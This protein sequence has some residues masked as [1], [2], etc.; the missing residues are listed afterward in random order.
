MN[1]TEEVV[2][3]S[4]VEGMR[5]SASTHKRY[6]FRSREEVESPILHPVNERSVRWRVS[7]TTDCSLLAEMEMQTAA[8]G[9]E[10]DPLIQLVNAISLRLR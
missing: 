7:G 9:E 3:E 4:A 6:T 8:D 1:E 10:V 5:E 2:S